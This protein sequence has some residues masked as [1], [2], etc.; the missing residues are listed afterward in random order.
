MPRDPVE[1]VRA[2]PRDVKALVALH[3]AAAEALTR[4]HGSGPWSAGRREAGLTTQVAAGEVWVVR[5]KAR[6]LATMRLGKKKP[7][8][9]DAA[10]FST[11]KSPLYLT[12]M[13]VQPLLQRTG[14]GRAALDAAVAIARREQHD[15]I[16]LDAYNA[17]AG[18][19]DFYRKCGW[20]ERGR[21][22]Y[23]ATP[24]IYFEMKISPT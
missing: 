10:Y 2:M 20:E 19:G 7:W 6:L 15:A 23:R 11:A 22:T 4:I 21:V 18:A 13:A 3:N 1:L 17:A 12:D 16:R 14:I 8:A 5:A 24:L 9:I